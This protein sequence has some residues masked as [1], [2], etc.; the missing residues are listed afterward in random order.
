MEN[1]NEIINS[2]TIPNFSTN[3]TLSSYEKLGRVNI[4]IL[5]DDAKVEFYLVYKKS[6][7]N[8]LLPLLKNL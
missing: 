1:L 7:Q 8:K 6:H 5:D 2:S 4:P 3:I